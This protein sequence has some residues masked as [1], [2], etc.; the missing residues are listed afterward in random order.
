[1]FAL[2]ANDKIDLYETGVH[3]HS[4]ERIRLYLDKIQRKSLLRKF[5]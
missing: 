5:S 2:F 1:M 4:G 3:D